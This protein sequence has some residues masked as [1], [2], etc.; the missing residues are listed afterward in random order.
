MGTAVINII[1]NSI[2]HSN[3]YL[4]NQSNRKF[5]IFDDYN[6]KHNLAARILLSQTDLK[7]LQRILKD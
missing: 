3:V 4:F 7:K 1:R 5:L 6:N 2:A